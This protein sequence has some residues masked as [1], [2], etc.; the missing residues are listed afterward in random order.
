MGGDLL[1][2]CRGPGHQMK[3]RGMGMCQ[4]LTENVTEWEKSNN[5]SNVRWFCKSYLGIHKMDFV[6][7]L[8]LGDFR[9]QKSNCKNLNRV[10]NKCLQF[11]ILTLVQ[12]SCK[13]KQR[14]IPAGMNERG[15]NPQSSTYPWYSV[16]KRFIEYSWLQPSIKDC[17]QTTFHPETN[18]KGIEQG[19]A[20][21]VVI[22]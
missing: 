15:V 14:T 5:T 13:S 10:K 12:C 3:I 9:P 8:G 7:A 2:Y 11:E 21:S 4:R 19:S 22:F 20:S 17:I 18:Q 1:K 6:K 16:N